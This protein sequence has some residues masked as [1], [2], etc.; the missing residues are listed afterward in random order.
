MDMQSDAD[1]DALRAGAV[2]PVFDET[3]RHTR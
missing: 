3:R 1:H 2:M